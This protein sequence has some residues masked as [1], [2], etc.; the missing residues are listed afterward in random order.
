M[1]SF[2]LRQRILFTSSVDT[3]SVSFHLSQFGA[4][5]SLFSGLTDV[6][7]R[8]L[9]LTDMHGSVQ[10]R[11]NLPVGRWRK[12]GLT[13]L[14]SV[15]LSLPISG[16]TQQCVADP[17]WLTA[18]APLTVF[19]HPSPARHPA[20]D[21]P[22]YQAA[23]QVFPY[24]TAPEKGT[25]GRV[26]PRFLASPDFRTIEETFGSQFTRA[27][28]ITGSKLKGLL[29]VAPMTRQRA[30][31]G[32]VEGEGADVGGGVDQAGSDSCVIDQNGNPIFF[33]IHFNRVLAGFFSA[34]H[35]LTPEDVKAAQEATKFRTLT[36]DDGSIELKS[37]W[38][39]VDD[40]NPPLEYFCTKA[41]VPWLTVSRMEN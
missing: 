17:S 22:F 15:F 10:L 8:R 18:K 35:L 27:F 23:W 7:C 20:P 29:S 25:D 32:E 16:R 21:C 12:F 34:N 1:V 41:V 39:V 11:S 19:A 30:N 24:A 26:V 28:P 4:I 5:L 13:T 9:A 36:F 6:L 38:Q 40:R 33:A 2:S 3:R 14:V 31:R 37:A